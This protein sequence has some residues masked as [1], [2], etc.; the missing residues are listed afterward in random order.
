[1]TSEKT[2]LPLLRVCVYRADSFCVGLG[3]DLD[4][5]VAGCFPTYIHGTF[6][7]NGFRTRLAR[8]QETSRRGGGLILVGRILMYV[9]EEA[10]SRSLA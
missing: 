8:T 1:M 3:P 4:G 2:Y 9:P 10:S 6:R 5:V 7:A